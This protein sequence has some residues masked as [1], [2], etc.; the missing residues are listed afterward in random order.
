MVEQARRMPRE[1]F[2]RRM[3][4]LVEQLSDALADGRH[5]IEVIGKKLRD[6]AESLVG[7]KAHHL[8]EM[9]EVPPRICARCG[10][11][12]HGWQAVCGRCQ[13]EGAEAK[14]RAELRAEIEAELRAKQAQK[15]GGRAD[16]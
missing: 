7:H 15:G 9:L 13:E 2:L 12:H 11:L 5:G 4:A 1:E 6:E 14:K 10:S 16:H 8:I 3:L